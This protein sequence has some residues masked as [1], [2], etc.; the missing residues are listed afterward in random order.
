MAQ[1][2]PAQNE[3]VPVATGQQATT[4]ALS[5]GSPGVPA[6][7]TSGGGQNSLAAPLGSDDS[8]DPQKQI[9]GDDLELLSQ[10]A[11]A[12]AIRSEQIHPVEGHA[13]GVGAVAF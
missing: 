2:I 11:K 6:P 9:L 1:T 10:L 5:P 12:L 3:V 8:G 4:I 13:A 7:Q